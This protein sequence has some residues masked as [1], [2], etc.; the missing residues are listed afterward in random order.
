[1]SESSRQRTPPDEVKQKVDEI[2]SD[3][4]CCD[5]AGCRCH[6]AK[7][8]LRLIADYAGREADDGVSTRY[9]AALQNAAAWKEH[10]RCRGELL[11]C[12][13]LGK[14]PS[15]A[16]WKRMEAAAVAAEKTEPKP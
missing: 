6:E 4:A 9:D 16:L 3:L 5:R 15:E 14:N 8:R 13:R 2:V 10:S 11:A 12:Y 7:E 1:M